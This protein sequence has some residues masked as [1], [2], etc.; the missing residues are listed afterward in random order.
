MGD[1]RVKRRQKDSRREGFSDEKLKPNIMINTGNDLHIPVI[2][3]ENSNKVRTGNMG[4]ISKLITST[5]P[6]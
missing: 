4:V 6:I 1:W 2:W 3:K 5:A